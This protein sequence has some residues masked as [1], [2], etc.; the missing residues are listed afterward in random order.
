MTVPLRLPLRGEE[1]GVFCKP[2]GCFFP[3][4]FASRYAVAPEH[5]GQFPGK[6]I[7]GIGT[8]YGINPRSDAA[9][10]RKIRGLPADAEY[11]L[12]IRRHATP[13]AARAYLA[14]ATD[15]LTAPETYRCFEPVRFT[16]DGIFTMVQIPT[17][18]TWDGPTIV[19]IA[20]YP[21]ERYD[22][23]EFW[24]FGLDQDGVGRMLDTGW[25]SSEPEEASVFSPRP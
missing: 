6:V 22:G 8:Y 13:D 17:K 3:A 15:V 23:P 18:A 25:S 24:I 14:G 12:L 5:I 7:E 16:D 9:Q 11:S 20:D 2:L 10:C 19:H 21:S 4:V 1:R